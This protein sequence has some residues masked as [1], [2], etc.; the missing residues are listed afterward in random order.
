MVGRPSVVGSEISDPFR[1]PTCQE[2]SLAHVPSDSFTV[3][4]V[5]CSVLQCVR[6]CVRAFVP[7]HIAIV[8]SSVNSHSHVSTCTI[9]VDLLCLFGFGRETDKGRPAGGDFSR[10]LK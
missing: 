7:A 9:K 10:L 1:G 8:C 3:C 4:A 2:A 5:Q 6:A